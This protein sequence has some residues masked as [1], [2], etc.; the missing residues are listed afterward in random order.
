MPIRSN[1]HMPNSRANKLPNV[2]LEM[3]RLQAQSVFSAS[4]TEKKKKREQRR[5]ILR[6]MSWK[7]KSSENINENNILEVIF[8]VVIGLK[9]PLLNLSKNKIWKR[10]KPSSFLW[11]LDK[12]KNK[13]ACQW[14]FIL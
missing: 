14:L 3:A 2:I 7:H 6:H 4:S 9:T 11:F 12:S 10:P 8:I 5:K 1:L 13:Q